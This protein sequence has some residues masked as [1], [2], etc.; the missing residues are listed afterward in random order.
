[1]DEL[2]LV[3]EAEALGRPCVILREG[4]GG[5]AALWGGP[6]IAE[7]PS[8]PFRHW[9]TIDCACLPWSPWNR[10]GC[11]AVYTNEE[12]CAS[13][14]V[15][16]LEGA[17]L[18]SIPTAGVKLV[19]E[20]STSLPPLDG[21]F[22]LG[23]QKVHA[24]LERLGWDPAGGYNDNFPAPSQP[25]DYEGRWQDLCPL[26]S[27]GI[28]AVLGGWHFPWPDGDWA[29]LVDHHLL[30]WTLE[31]SEPWVEAWSDDE[32]QWVIQRVT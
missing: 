28:H 29:S 20:P 7:P 16:F 13:G 8:G 30:V 18:P 1:M 17:A 10:P 19:A 2:N 31:D 9:L 26:Y 11:C 22:L 15:V 24:W 6:G 3:Q 21:V 5:Y 4:A 32:R 23:S 27:G 14:A 25:E 12:D